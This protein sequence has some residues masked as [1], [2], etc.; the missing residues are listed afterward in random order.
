MAGRRFCRVTRPEERRW[1]LEVGAAAGWRQA[2]GPCGQSDVTRPTR[3]EGGNG[4]EDLSDE[5]PP[6]SRNW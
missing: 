3:V 5:G 4:A 1:C 2:P 6:V